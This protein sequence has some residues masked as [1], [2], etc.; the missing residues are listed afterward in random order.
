MKK[1][2][3]CF[4]IIFSAVSFAQKKGA[5][6]SLPSYSYQ[7]FN[8]SNIGYFDPNTYKKE[9][10]DGVYQLLYTFTGVN[11]DS[12]PVFKLSDVEDIRKNK[13]TYLQQLEK[14]YQQKKKALYSLKI[15][16]QPMWKK[17]QQETIQTFENEY[18]LNKDNIMGFADPASLKS[19]P[20]YNTCKEYVDAATSGDKQ[21]M[22]AVWKKFVEAKS[23]DNADP[24]GVMIR[25]N[26]KLNDSK[27]DDYALIDLIGF[28]FHNCANGSFRPATDDEG[29]AYTA[30][31]KIFTKLKADC[32][33]P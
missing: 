29:K 12:H 21:K 2:F 15:I 30:F 31:D 3:I 28:G 32:D 23:K 24:K 6:P 8:C 5:K 7:T 4:S 17:L 14:Q 22:Y 18:Q 20:Y 11:F 16:N 19:S 1:V 25:F 33:E 13:D 27:K 10:I 26:E 9:E